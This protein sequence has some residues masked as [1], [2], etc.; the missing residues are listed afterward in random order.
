MRKKS[1]KVINREEYVLINGIEQYI[2]H[3]GTSESNPVLLFLHGGPGSAVSIFGHAFQKQ[4]EDLYTVVHWD[5]RGAGKTLTK[6]PSAHASIETMIEDTHAIIQY[7]KKTY[8]QEKVIILGHSWGS[9]LGS[10]IVKKYPEDVAY[11]IGV[12]QV[13]SILENER[14]GYEKLKQAII[15]ANDQKSLKKLE[16]IG[17]YPGAKFG[18]DMLPQC[19]KVR[20]LQGKYNLAVQIGLPMILAAF[21]S[22]IFKCS[23]MP[24]AVKGM[25][26]N[27]QVLDFLGEFDLNVESP[28]YEVPMYYILGDR[29][30]QTPFSIA[31]DY[32]KKIEAPAKKLYLI[33]DAG[34]MT[35]MDQPDLFYKTLVEI[36]KKQK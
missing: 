22:P 7:L 5:Q 24:A 17:E 16:A 30:W 23:D 10:I 31:S 21:K 3:Q 13:I 9:V 8:R 32:F 12:G 26:A 19:G 29:D 34:H 15:Q 28:R 2:Y 35:M 1:N 27:H 20:Q 11:Y 6:N 33:P 25:K 18:S 36:N 14:V 4:W